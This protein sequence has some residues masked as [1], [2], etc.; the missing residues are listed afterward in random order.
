MTE[1]NAPE[2]ERKFLIAYPDLQYLAEKARRS[3]IVQTYL[4]SE[5]GRSSR[6]RKRSDGEKTVYTFTEKQHIT[7]VRRME[8][9]REISE[10][11]YAELLKK[12]DRSRNPIEKDRYCLDYAG[13]M[14]EIDVYPFFTD[15]AIME[16]ELSDE[17]QTILFPPEIKVIREVTE[18]NRY[19]NAAFARK[20][21]YD[22]I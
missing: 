22:D 13:Q 18:D 15:R 17:A 9:E 11:E 4:A 5:N 14:F 10:T 16:L 20:I 12:A 21:P 8:Y 6:V 7:A 19:T 2:I 1:K 3:H